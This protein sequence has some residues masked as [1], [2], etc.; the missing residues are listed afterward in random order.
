VV[1]ALA[2]Q[3]L[4]RFGAQQA[5]S[6]DPPTSGQPHARA[7]DEIDLRAVSERTVLLTESGM[8]L[9]VDQLV[10]DVPDPGVVVALLYDAV[11]RDAQGR[12]NFAPPP[13][14]CRETISMVSRA[15]VEMS[16]KL[17]RHMASPE[18]SLMARLDLTQ[19]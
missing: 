11:P 19:S 18:A 13:S 2:V 5:A 14:Q 12:R 15:D 8:P 7:E 1:Q 10:G 4:R 17:E 3:E 16:A 6:M 9:S